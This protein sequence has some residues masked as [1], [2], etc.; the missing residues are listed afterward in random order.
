[1]SVCTNS[2]D[3][4]PIV[5]ARNLQAKDLADMLPA[6]KKQLDSWDTLVSPL[7]SKSNDDEKEGKDEK[8]PAVSKK[9]K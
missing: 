3:M 5:A 7:K 4:N 2:H 8:Q 9:K 6:V 1:M